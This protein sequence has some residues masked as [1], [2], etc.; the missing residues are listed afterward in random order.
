MKSNSRIELSKEVC[1]YSCL[2]YTLVSETRYPYM[3]ARRITKLLVQLPNARESSA[4]GFY[5]I[6]YSG[7]SFSKRL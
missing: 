7:S 2:I 5:L 6:S 3:L 1:G 4:L